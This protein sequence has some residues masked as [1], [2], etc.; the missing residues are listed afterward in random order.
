DAID[1]FAFDEA[2]PVGRV[3]VMGEGRAAL[4][5]ANSSLG[6]ALA[7]DEIDYLC[8]RFTELGRNPTDAELMMIAQA[9]T[10]HCSKKKYHASYTIDGEVAEKSLFDMIR[11]TFQTHP[12]Q[13]LSAYKVNAA[14][15]EGYTAPRFFPKAATGVYQ[16]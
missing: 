13:V 5:E 8:E 11:N 6:L 14:V 1:F 9:N 12:G 16:E 3:A 7:E 2:G 15:T 10:E 4:E